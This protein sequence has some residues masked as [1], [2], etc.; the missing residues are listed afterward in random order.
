M[1]LERYKLNSFE[2]AEQTVSPV[3]FRNKVQ[4]GLKTQAD[5]DLVESHYNM[6]FTDPARFGDWAGIFIRVPHIEYIIDLKNG[7][8]VL[9]LGLLAEQ[10]YLA[11]SIAEQGDVNKR[12]K[13]VLHNEAEIDELKVS[14]YARRAK[15][16]S[17]IT[18][19][20]EK[21]PKY[22]V[23]VCRYLLSSS[24]G[25]Q[26]KNQAFVKLTE[27]IEGK[28]SVDGKKGEAV[29]TVL[30]ALDPSY[31]GSL[32]KETLY[33][34]LD[35]SDAIYHNIIRYDNTKQF[36]YNVAAEGSNY[37]RTRDD[38][39]AYLSAVTNADHLG[40]GSFDDAPYSVRYQ[41]EK[42]RR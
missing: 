33:I 25:I 38:V 31:G 27:Y 5:I 12:Y 14:I 36:Y 6:S 19:I 1:G 4:H 29:D 40:T 11:P 10:G 3:I 16:I 42:L 32:T 13:F 35:V 24:T 28:L 41:L 34:S 8:D 23:A 15:A 7:Q 37:G 17:K 30:A 26:N 22:L 9:M 39:M 2:G 18:E 21:E 20:L